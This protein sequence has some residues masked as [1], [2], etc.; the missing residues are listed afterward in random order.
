M[1]LRDRRRSWTTEP[2]KCVQDKEKMPWRGKI[3]IAVTGE[4]IGPFGLP[5]SQQDLF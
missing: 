3:Q 2:D 1:D 5:R 4:V